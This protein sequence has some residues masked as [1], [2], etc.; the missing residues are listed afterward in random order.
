[1]GSTDEGELSPHGQCGYSCRGC[2][3]GML[4]RR[5]V[6]SGGEEE[7]GSGCEMLQ[8]VVVARGIAMFHELLLR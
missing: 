6:M 7:M 1:M 5:G 4:A 3:V 2:E 8:Y